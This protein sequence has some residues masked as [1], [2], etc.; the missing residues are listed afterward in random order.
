[1]LNKIILG[2]AQFGMN[3]GINNYGALSKTKVFNILDFAMILAQ[4]I[5]LKY[6]GTHL[7]K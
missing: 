4:L 3:Y 6:M 5:L 2:S 7:K 1:M